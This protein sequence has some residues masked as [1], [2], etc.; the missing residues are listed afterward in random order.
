MG[1]CLQVVPRESAQSEEHASWQDRSDGNEGGRN[2]CVGGRGQSQGARKGGP[3]GCGGHKGGRARLCGTTREDSLLVVKVTS[4]QTG[5]WS[6][7][8]SKNKR[9]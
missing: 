8:S 6:N 2:H 3:G 7:G 4:R 1:I 9:V 5:H